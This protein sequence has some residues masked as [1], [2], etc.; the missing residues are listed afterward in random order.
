[1]NHTIGMV[2]VDTALSAAS[3][4]GSSLVV[5]VYS[6]TSIIRADRRGSP[7]R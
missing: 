3:N 7:S 1:M 4:V 5:V 2:V 6:I